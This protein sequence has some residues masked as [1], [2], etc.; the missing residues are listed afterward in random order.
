MI[1]IISDFIKKAVFCTNDELEGT[2]NQVF[3]IFSLLKKKNP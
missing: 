2:Q 3:D 1:F